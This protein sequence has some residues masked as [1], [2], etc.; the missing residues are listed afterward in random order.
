M[1]NATFRQL[2]DHDNPDAGTFSQ[3][4]YY[5]DEFYGGPGFPVVL[6]NNGEA[7][8]E[9]GVSV[10][11]KNNSITGAFAQEIRGAIIIL[12]HRYWGRSSPYDNLT[13]ENLQYLTLRNSIADM[14][15]FARNVE[16]PF[17][18]NCSSN[19]PQAPWVL[20]GGSYSGA[21]AAWT[22]STDPGTFWAY[23]ASSAPVQ[24]IQ[25]YWAYSLPIQEGMPQNCSKDMSRVISHVDSVL[26]SGSASNITAL[27]TLFGLQKIEHNDDFASALMSPLD[28]WQNLVWDSSSD[29]DQFCD[30]LESGGSPGKLSKNSNG[31]VPGA[32]GVGLKTALAGYAA[33]YNQVYSFPRDGSG[34]VSS[35]DTY[36][37]STKFY[38][39]TSVNNQ[40]DRQWQWM[41]CNTPFDYWMESGFPSSYNESV[42][43]RHLHPSH[44][45]R[46]CDLF[47]PPVYDEKVNYTYTFNWAGN[48]TEDVNAYTKG[49]DLTGTTRLMWA[50]GEF[51][52]WRSAGVSSEIRPGG[53]LAD[54]DAAPVGLIPDGHHCWDLLWDEAAPRGLM[55]V[56][57]REVRVMHDWVAEFYGGSIPA[58]SRK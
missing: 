56:V 14:T 35:Y 39:D 3:F 45:Q 15:Y 38:T 4:Y 55:D 12:E 53:P 47:F 23:H 49:W 16:L 31:T 50:N 10:Y 2:L 20:S 6:M 51:D 44:Q 5:S 17:D 22:A 54:S 41:L 32:D 9:S 19:A 7:A 25:D 1:R 36:D 37:G 27:K 8:E 34:D 13:T 29:V 52:P 11:M 30:Y 28:S 33:Y 26:D 57:D 18:K 58:P 48:S 46:Q 43:S 24:A 21:L 42:V 40:A